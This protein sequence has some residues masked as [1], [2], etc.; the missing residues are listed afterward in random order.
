VTHE[1]EA[2]GSR[3]IGSTP[4]RFREVLKADTHHNRKLIQDN[5]IKPDE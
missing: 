5:A 1:L 3:I 2:E 4:A